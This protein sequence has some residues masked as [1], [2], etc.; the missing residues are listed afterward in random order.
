MPV[1]N[2]FFWWWQATKGSAVARKGFE[3]NSFKHGSSN[4]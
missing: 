4:F 2:Y 1:E 3:T